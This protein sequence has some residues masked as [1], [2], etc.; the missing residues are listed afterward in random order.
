M[1][2]VKAFVF[3]LGAVMLI[4]CFGMWADRRRYPAPAIQTDDFEGFVVAVLLLA[5]VLFFWIWIRL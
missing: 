4:L 5:G 3:F 1:I 2:I